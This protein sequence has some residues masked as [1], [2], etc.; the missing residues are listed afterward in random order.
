MFHAYVPF[1]NRTYY[2]PIQYNIQMHAQ[3]PYRLHHFGPV[4]ILWAPFNPDGA[5]LQCWVR[6]LFNSGTIAD[7]ILSP[8]HPHMPWRV[9]TYDHN[10]AAHVITT[11]QIVLHASD[12]ISPNMLYA[13]QA[14][15]NGGS[16]SNVLLG[17]WY[18]Y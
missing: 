8:Y 18:K 13:T 5:I 12:G 15:W 3:F 4:G 11:G 1:L 7:D 6:V 9:I 2:S 16:A 10:A 17:S 14:V